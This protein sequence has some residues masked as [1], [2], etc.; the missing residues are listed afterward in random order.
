MSTFWLKRSR[1]CPT[2]KP[3]LTSM[4]YILYHFKCS[5][6]LTVMLFHW[7]LISFLIKLLCF[8]VLLSFNKKMSKINLASQILK[9]VCYIVK[10]VIFRFPNPGYIIIVDSIALNMQRDPT[11]CHYLLMKVSM[12]FIVSTRNRNYTNLHLVH[13]FLHIC[14]HSMTRDRIIECIRPTNCL[15]GY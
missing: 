12:L 13:R 9:S 14:F 6:L 7:Y 2:L 15:G 1:I 10:Q 8:F 3:N 5:L 4:M 11:F